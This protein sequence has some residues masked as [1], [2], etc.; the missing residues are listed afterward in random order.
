MS[1]EELSMKQLSLIPLLMSSLIMIGCGGGGSSS[2]QAPGIPSIQGKYETVAQSTTYPGKALLIEATVME[3]GSGNIQSSGSHILLGGAGWPFNPDSGNIWL[4]GNCQGYENG[5]SLSGTVNANNSVTLTLNENGN[6]FNTTG[7]IS[8]NQITGTYQSPNGST[9]SDN[10]AFASTKLLV[11]LSG[12]F[13]TQSNGGF[14]HSFSGVTA[15]LSEDS[16]HNMTVIGMA[17]GTPYTL[18]GVVAGNAFSANGDMAGQS[19][20]YLGLFQ[21]TPVSTGKTGQLYFYDS[22]SPCEPGHCGGVPVG[23]Y[24]WVGD[25]Y[26]Q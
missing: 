9:C 11:R 14:F 21:P 12:S 2:N 20:H 10:G 6:L 16:A 7:T 24:N 26:A 13:S 4:G 18:T 25:L 15:S 5:A 1:G 3:D 8:N 17:D 19:V 22:T 23:T